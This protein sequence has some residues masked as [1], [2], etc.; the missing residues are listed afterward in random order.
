MIATVNGFEVSRLRVTRPRK[1]RATLEALVIAEPG[2]IAKEQAVRCSVGGVTVF[3]GRAREADRAA[4]TM[5]VVARDAPG[6]ETV[7]PPKFYR[8]ADEGLVARDVLRE[9]GET[10]DVTLTTAVPFYVRRRCKASDVL[11][12]LLR[13]SGE[14]W[15]TRPGGAV[16]VGK[17]GR[18]P[19]GQVFKWG[20]TLYD[21]DPVTQTYRA[22]L[23]PGLEAGALVTLEPY[24]ERRTAL[25]DRLEHVIEGGEVFTK[26]WTIP[27]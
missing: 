18:E 9:V 14:L 8:Q 3:T 10:P 23:T 22:A 11:A 19:F 4:G 7:V 20:E 21:F 2:S 25:V 6:L 27:G 16:F 13:D 12:D 15:R 24:H 17:E 1:G 5:K 26:L